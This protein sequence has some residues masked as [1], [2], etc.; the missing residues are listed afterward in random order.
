MIRNERGRMEG[1]RRGREGRE[2]VKRDIYDGFS[3]VKVD[4]EVGEP[5]HESRA[6][7]VVRHVPLLE[8]RLF[9]HGVGDP[10]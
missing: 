7:H 6:A 8:V 9:F 1:S 4:V 5:S 3:I 2:G 10:S